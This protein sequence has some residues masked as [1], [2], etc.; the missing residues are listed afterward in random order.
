MLP[1]ESS[2]MHTL[3]LVSGAAHAALRLPPLEWTLP[4]R[5]QDF[6]AQDKC[7]RSRDSVFWICH[8]RKVYLHLRADRPTQDV[9]REMLLTIHWLR[10]NILFPVF[11]LDG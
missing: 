9:P 6:P 7:V 5:I 8:S 11:P 4:M 1:P 2:S 10:L 3:R